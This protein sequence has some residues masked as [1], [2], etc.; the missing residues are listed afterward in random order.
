[1]IC[2]YWLDYPLWGG[3]GELP[4]SGPG[5]YSARVIRVQETNGNALM[6]IVE[7]DSVNHAPV[8]PFNITVQMIG[9]RNVIQPGERIAFRSTVTSPPVK[10]ELPDI[11]SENPLD[12]RYRVVGFSMVLPDSLSYCLP[13]TGLSARMY[14]L[15]S[16][17]L[18][19]LSQSEL[20]DRAFSLLSAMLLGD[21]TSLTP[22]E[23]NA[24]SASGLSHLLA[25]SGTHV[26]VIVSLIALALFPLTVARRNR[27]RFLLSLILLWF[28]A[29]L[30]GMSPSVVR[31]AV[32]A[33]VYMVGR[34]LQRPSVPINSLCFAAWII[35]MVEPQELFMP[36]FQ[37]S[38][39]A[40]AGIIVF[41]PLL[42]RIDRR[43][44]PRL[45][46]LWSYPAVSISA[47]LLTGL[48]ATWYFH[49]FPL[50]FLPANLLAVPL[51]PLILALGLLLLLAPS[52]YPVSWLVN[53]LCMLLDSIAQWIAGL[54]LAVVGDVYLPLWLT[55]L[56]PL[57]LLCAGLALQYR[58]YAA[59]IAS[60]IVFLTAC[61]AGLITR[62]RFPMNESFELD[63]ATVI[64]QGDCVK[65]FTEIKNEAD[66]RD[67]TVY[68]SR[69]LR[70]Y[71]ARRELPP[72]E[73]IERVEN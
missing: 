53:A 72:P 40:V 61:I 65:V 59:A 71:C 39:A 58:R 47:M 33:T 46:F 14:R 43:K 70:H 54:P 67:A 49:T 6:G 60:C 55:L 18:S 24:Y 69:R 68:F 15:N 41:Y 25:L 45:Y 7:V 63:G 19:R 9:H 22:D 52:F 66:R 36:G 12:R 16:H 21:K 10:P 11:V 51:I 8:A 20:D 13:G 31:A 29:L 17:M 30:T 1:M 34:I 28:Y 73:I 42:N 44:H 37:M 38:F 57:F 3:K 23:V 4:V 5:F 62:P 2:E 50:Y 35:L 56:L 64:R 27:I 26:A 48:I 32:M